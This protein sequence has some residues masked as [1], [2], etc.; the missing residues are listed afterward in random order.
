MATSFEDGCRLT[1]DLE[2]EILVR[3]P[4]E[5][6]L[7]FKCVCKSWYTLINSPR[8]IREYLG[9]KR[10]PQLLI[11]DECNADE[12]EDDPVPITII[13]EDKTPLV[14]KFDHDLQTQGF[15]DL[16]TLIGSVDGLFL[17]QKGYV[18]DVSLALWNPATREVRP[19]PAVKF[20]LHPIFVQYR[21][22]FGFGLD[23]FTSNNYKVVWFRIVQNIDDEGIRAYAAV[24]SCSTDSWRTLQPID[25]KIIN[26]KVDFYR[27]DFGDA[28][29][30][31]AYYWL[32]KKGLK[33]S[34]LSFD[35]GS[36]V[37]GEIGG[38]N[39]ASSSYL[40]LTSL[41]LLDDSIAMLNSNA[42]RSVYDIWVLIQ[43]GAAGVWNKLLTF[44]CSY[45]ISYSCLCG[46][47]DSSTF[48][49]LTVD[50]ET[51]RGF[52]LV[53]YDV[54]TQETR[55]LG[56]RHQR[57][58]IACKMVIN[59]SPSDFFMDSVSVPNGTAIQGLTELVLSGVY[60]YRL[61]CFG[62][63]IIASPSILAVVYSIKK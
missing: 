54:R 45:H 32:L 25:N 55:H 34:V 37:F 11:Y 35:F 58:R 36:E 26:S 5:S 44:K 47:W 4:V 22:I 19:L 28:Y 43:P 48:I 49:F 6:S 41:I 17:L 12:D 30:N 9:N 27:E 20:V 46:L 24:Y 61:S 62:P 8:F 2:R 3:L 50:Q 14:A 56:Y 33:L 29:L 63:L 53:S 16:S 7:R 51:G 13:S 38:P 40:D 57:R 39:I 59:E 23:P 15:G 60:F 10:R 21:G 42:D 31:G 18:D 1:E 52:Q